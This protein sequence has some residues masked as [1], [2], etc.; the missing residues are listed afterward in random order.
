MVT[1]LGTITL[2]TIMAAGKNKIQSF[3][4]TFKK[5]D[6]ILNFANKVKNNEIDLDSFATKSD[7][8]II[9]ELS[10]LEGIGEWTEEMVLL[11]CL[12]CPDILSYK[13]LAIIK[14]MKMV[15]HHKDMDKKRFERYRKR[16]SPFGS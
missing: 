5:A 7:H 2:E 11:R 4:M 13:D 1:E 9:N 10:S 14:G 8:E 3:G 12:Q 15:Y 16:F 6:D